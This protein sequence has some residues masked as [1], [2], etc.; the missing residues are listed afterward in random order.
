MSR[1]IDSEVAKALGIPVIGTMPCWNTGRGC[2]VWLKG[3]NSIVDPEIEDCP[4]YPDYDRR[5]VCK[6]KHNEWQTGI[7]C[8]NNDRFCCLTP[9]LEYSSKIEGA[10]QVVEWMREKGWEFYLSWEPSDNGQAWGVA[11]MFYG[12]GPKEYRHHYKEARTAPEAICRTFLATQGIEL[13][14]QDETTSTDL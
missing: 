12:D 13:N 1:E 2:I 5:A 9:V 11:F 14:G 10:W 8:S 6:D 4:V 3:P 7:Q